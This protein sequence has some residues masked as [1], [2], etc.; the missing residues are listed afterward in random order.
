MSLNLSKLG[1]GCWQLGSTGPEDYWGM[2]YTQEDANKM[3]KASVE[4]GVFYLDT[5]KDYAKGGSEKQLGE[6]IKTL[7][8]ELRQ[9]VVIGSKIPPN[10]CSDVEGTLQVSWL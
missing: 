1:F 9:K 3:I 8:P 2:E 7:D 5:A 10:D 6:A 4:A